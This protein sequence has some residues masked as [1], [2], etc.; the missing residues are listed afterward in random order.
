MNVLVG[1]LTFTV[2]LGLFVF[3][4]G[5]ASVV[6]GLL[7]GEADHWTTVAVRGVGILAM[8]FGFVTLLGA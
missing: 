6:A 2:G 4:R 1:L 5:V 3:P 7:G 8:A